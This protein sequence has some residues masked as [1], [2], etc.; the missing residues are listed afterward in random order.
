MSQKLYSI[1]VPINAIHG[2]KL[3][4]CINTFLHQ[5]IL[6]YI[7]YNIDILR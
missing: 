5:T 7:K 1:Y 2:Q 4:K 6:Y 3:T